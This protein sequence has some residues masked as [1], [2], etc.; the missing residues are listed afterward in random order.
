MRG[1]PK[2]HKP[3]IPMRPITSGIGSAPHRLAKRL[4]KPLSN[5]LGSISQA[6]LKNSTDLI[7]RLNNVD[8]KGKEMASFDVKALFTSVPKEGAMEA[9]KEAVDKI[10]EN[11]L[12]VSKSDYIKL[13]S[14]CVSFDPFT[15][16]GKVYRQHQ[17]LAMGSPLSALWSGEE[18]GRYGV[19][20]MLA[21]DIAG[22]A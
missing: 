2:I 3:G 10:S 4:A 13:I 7:N 16:S 19:T 1:L 15:F 21:P 22:M 5:A 12:P 9:V 17:G 11:E 6:H 8:F 14:L 18:D 20:F